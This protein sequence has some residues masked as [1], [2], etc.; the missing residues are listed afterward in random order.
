MLLDILRQFNWVDIFLVILIL[1][2]CYVAT[3]FGLS[4]EIFKL[5]GTILA[6]YLSLHYYTVSSD[7]IKQRFGA[8]NIP[9]E[10]LDFLIFLG[11]NIVGYLTF[12]LL[13]N[14]F[15]RFIKM[16]AMPGLNKWGGLVFGIARGSL[17][18]SLVIFMLA[19]SSIGYFKNSVH[20]SYSGSR[21]FKIAPATYSVVW[22]NLMSKFMPQEK[23]NNTILEVQEDFRQ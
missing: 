15:Y 3:K 21:I 16:E 4:A 6:I 14:L 20:N 22:N 18:V 19:I 2:I 11:L 17:T 7:W 10:F 12:V 5:A 9:L 1:R 23:F 13:R 8:E